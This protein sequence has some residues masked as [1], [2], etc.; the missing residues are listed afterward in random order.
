[1][2]VVHPKHLEH[3]ELE[4]NCIVFEQPVDVHDVCYITKKIINTA[5][6][7]FKKCPELKEGEW[8]GT[9]IPPRRLKVYFTPD[10]EYEEAEAIAERL[11]LDW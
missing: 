4:E 6:W 3:F 1:M 8:E 9:N 7:F 2:S 10:L 11:G 5:A